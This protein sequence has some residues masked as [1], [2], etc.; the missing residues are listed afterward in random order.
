M[1]SRMQ[2]AF[3]LDDINRRVEVLEDKANTHRR[4]LEILAIKRS[5]PDLLSDEEVDEI[6]A[7]DEATER[8]QKVFEALLGKKKEEGASDVSV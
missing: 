2:A 3:R 4:K 1:R 7:Q 6:T 5:N 8:T